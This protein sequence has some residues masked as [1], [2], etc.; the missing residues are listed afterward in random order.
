MIC[1]G[2]GLMQIMAS[3]FYFIAGD[4]PRAAIFAGCATASIATVYCR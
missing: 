3:G 1:V 2:V 4:Y